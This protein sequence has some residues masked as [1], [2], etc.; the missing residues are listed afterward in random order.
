[1]LPVRSRYNRL[2]G[3]CVAASSRQGTDKMGHLLT[4]VNVYHEGDGM[5]ELCGNDPQVLQKKEESHV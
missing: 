2:G 5:L 4:R 3:L 1:M